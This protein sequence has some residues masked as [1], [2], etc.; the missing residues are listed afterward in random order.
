MREFIIYIQS[1]N[2]SH[3]TYMNR[4]NRLGLIKIFPVA[5]S[6]Q[7]TT[8]FNA[9]NKFTENAL[10][11]KFVTE[12]ETSFKQIKS[13][14]SIISVLNIEADLN[15]QYE[16]Q[17]VIFNRTRNKVIFLLLILHI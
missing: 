4:P 17:Q 5:V 15:L 11:Y 3:R 7:F 16:L 2:V 6:C 13:W 9:T 1:M 8:L 12:H 10:T 14:K